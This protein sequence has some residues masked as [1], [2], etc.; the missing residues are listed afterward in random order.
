M[1]GSADPEMQEL[2]LGGAG[3]PERYAES[4]AT[5][6]LPPLIAQRFDEPKIYFDLAG[7]LCMLADFEHDLGQFGRRRRGI[8]R[9]W[10]RTKIGIFPAKAAGFPR[11]IETGL[12]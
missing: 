6:A 11:E 12:F 5:V 2:S 10:Q 9:Q 8:D 3:T 1:L 7:Q 4:L